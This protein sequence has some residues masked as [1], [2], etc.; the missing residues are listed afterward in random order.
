M[1]GLVGSFSNK[2]INIETIDRMIGSL[3]HRGPD[4]Q[5][6]HY[7]R[8]FN[9]FFGHTRLSILD[10]SDNANQPIFSSC[11]RYILIFN[12]EI[13]NYLQIKNNLNNSFHIKWSGNGD[14]EVIINSIEKIGFHKTLSKLKGMFALAVLD[15]KL[16]KI[17]F[18]RDQFGEKPLYFGNNNSRF[19]FSS[20]LKAITSDLNF[21]K[22]INPLSVK[23]LMS[24]NYIP[25]PLSIYKN[26]HKLKHGHY[27][28]VILDNHNYDNHQFNQTKYVKDE[29]KYKENSYNFEDNKKKLKELF[30]NSV[31]NKMVSDVEVGSFLSSGVDSSLVASAMTKISKKKIKTFSLGYDNKNY[32]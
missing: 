24:L 14:T 17:F 5:A 18:A 3:K 13:Y 19:Y 2:E 1:C 28:E 26:I 9:L 31:E 20:E 30:F 12:G 10:I 21:N 29:K 4:N 15:N 27:L 22:Q 7:E 32:D 8:K 23:Y 11:G 16:N 25:S 6:Y